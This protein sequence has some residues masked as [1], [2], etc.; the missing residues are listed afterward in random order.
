MGSFTWGYKFMSTG[1]FFLEGSAK[2]G[3]WKVWPSLWSSGL[4]VLGPVVCGPVVSGPLVPWSSGPVVPWFSGPVVLWALVSGPVVSG[5][6]VRWSF[7]LLVPW[8]LVY[9][10]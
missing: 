2:V 7:D 4:L 5:H 6:A 3:F 9:R 8:S 1:P 10:F